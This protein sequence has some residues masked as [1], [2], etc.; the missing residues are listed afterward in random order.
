M[1]SKTE[2]IYLIGPMGAGKTTIGR[3]LARQLNKTFYDSDRVIEQR[4]GA[5]VA[6]I[7]ELEQESGFR[8]RERD[9]IDE[10]TQL[11]NVILATGG[12]AILD[13]QNRKHL[14]SRGYVVYLYAPISQLVLRTAKDKN[15]PLLQLDNPKQKLEELMAIRDPLYRE[16]A[17]IIVETGD[18]PIKNVVDN[19]IRQLTNSAESDKT[20]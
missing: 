11:N 19:L 17:D 7:F 8:K 4:T 18:S 16:I 2:N 20:P 15:R 5:S 10:L 12:G 9:I 13:E 1:A 3:V 6:L 14:A